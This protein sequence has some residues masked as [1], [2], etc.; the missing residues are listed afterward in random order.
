MRPS[1]LRQAIAVG[2][3]ALS[4]L[5]G[6]GACGNQVD[7]SKLL[8]VLMSKDYPDG[9]LTKSQA[10]CVADVMIKRGRQ[11]DVID[12]SEGKRTLAD[13]RVDSDEDFA[14]DQAHCAVHH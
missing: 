9:G 13:V 11:S 2:C 8:S 12:Y 1:G 4:L 3:A 6:L 10:E 7:R 5:V 14:V